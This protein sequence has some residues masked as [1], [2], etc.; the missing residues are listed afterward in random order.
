VASGVAFLFLFLLGMKLV[1][2]GYWQSAAKS[3]EWLPIGLALSSTL[4]SDP[5]SAPSQAK[6]PFTNL[7]RK[8]LIFE[9]M[10]HQKAALIFAIFCKSY[11]QLAAFQRHQFLP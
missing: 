8:I 9:L 3:L 7:C 4:V 1:V 10:Q 11:Q 5:F 6:H 2:A